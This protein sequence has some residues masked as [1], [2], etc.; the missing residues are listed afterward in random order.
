MENTVP[1]RKRGRPPKMAGRPFKPVSVSLPPEQLERLEAEARASGEPSLSAV[2]RVAVSEH[3]RRI[4]KR[5][6]RSAN[7]E[8]QP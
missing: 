4:D 2:V 5:R 8:N 6:E 7:G 3:L 1:T